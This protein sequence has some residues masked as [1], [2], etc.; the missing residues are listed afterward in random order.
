MAA[1]SDEVLEKLF[2]AAP[3][4]MMLCSFPEGEVRR[5]NT[6]A[7]ELFLAGRSIKVG[8]IIGEDVWSAFSNKLRGGGFIDDYEVL[9][10]TAY[11]ESFYGVLSGQLI[12]VGDEK[13]ILIGASDITDRKHAE[14]TMLRFF[15]GAPMVMILARIYDGMILRV[16]RRASELF[17]SSD[18][19][20][21]RYLDGIMGLVAKT[22]FIDRLGGG[23]FLDNFE[24]ELTTAYGEKFWANLSGQVMEIDE[25]RS[26]LIGVS[27]I[28]DRKRGEDELRAAKDEAERATKSKSLFLAT[29]S[30]EI[31]TPM[32]GVLGM[33]DLLSTTALTVEQDEM[34]RIIGDSAST[35]L[36][37]IDDI[38]DVSKIEAGKMH[39]E[40]VSTKLSELLES[41]LD[42]VAARARD[43]DIE[44][45][46]LLDADVPDFIFGDPVRLRQILL[47]LLGN[48]VKFTQHGHVALKASLTGQDGS[49]ISVRF[50]V[51]DTGI[52]LTEEQQAR[53]FQPFS[54][55]DDS[56][57]R[58]F[59]GT[60]LG[61]SICRR[62]VSM[63]G[64][65]IGVTSRENS[66]STF[67]FEVPLET[68]P[69]SQT[70][71]NDFNGITVLVMDNALVSRKCIS[72]ILQRHGAQIV[73]VDSPDDLEQILAGPI[74]FDL[75]LID[76]KL[77]TPAIL[78]AL[79]RRLDSSRIIGLT[80]SVVPNGNL[81]LLS[82]PIHSP[83]MLRVLNV[84][85]G[86]LSSLDEMAAS[87]S[88]QAIAPPSM[89]HALETGQLILVAEDNRTNQLVIG[90]QL[91]RLGYAFEIVN[92]GEEAWDAL[93]HK[94]YGLLL[95]DCFMPRLDGYLL[96]GRIRQHEA[97][98]GKAH[99][100]PI[101][102]LTAS[103]L[104]DDA[105][106]CLRSGMDDY[107]SKPIALDRLSKTLSKW[108][109]QAV[110]ETKD[111]P[112]P[113]DLAKLTEILGDDDPALHAEI[114]SFFAE[115]FTELQ[116]RID[117]AL[118]TKNRAELR[119]SAHSAKGAA[120]NAGATLLAASLYTLEHQALKGKMPQLQTLSKTI[121][122][123]FAA[124]Q[125]FISTLSP[126]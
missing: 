33:L 44:M 49:F 53:L 17:D 89:E 29:M 55:A 114:L 109:T 126:S 28:S 95:T 30:H 22:I 38:L 15:D 118:G 72:G 58:R 63:M 34:V 36:T 57:T 42:L 65:D 31:R 124:V 12:K 113:I 20:H 9:L 122:E 13:C 116:Q 61:L 40:R 83:H 84:V 123:Q 93:H 121:K 105:D 67:W 70:S 100:L 2:N 60:G 125:K 51:E 35:L 92:D 91:T 96:T 82:K 64:G 26:V 98:S 88:Q 62:L 56:T 120:Q 4:P 3:L 46:W 18:A 81:E 19:E 41:T 106:K 115:C 77:Q 66:G 37:I 107:L 1:N 79:R 103:A 52:G 117:A 16:N 54:Q 32:N 8:S 108:M 68:A 48:A 86:R 102:A 101:I 10:N 111:G 119:N 99:H 76:E 73:Q 25:I 74:R 11:G 112:C 39:L 104:R 90:K 43:K 85:L 69:Q 50:E 59:G 97:Q 23:G 80:R 110:P 6:R 94:K 7:N 45:A 47:N 5:S 71:E 87:R 27:D 78:S 75:G 21:K 24:A 14:D